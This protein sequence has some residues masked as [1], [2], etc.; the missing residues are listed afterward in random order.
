MTI[1]F[2][3]IFKLENRISA[4][5]PRAPYL[6]IAASALLGLASCSS[7][8]TPTNAA[9]AGCA[10]CPEMALVDGGVFLMGRDG[11]EPKRY[12]GPVRRI[13]IDKPYYLSKYEVTYAQFEAFV[14]AENYRPVQ[15][16]NVFQNGKWGWADWANWQN[17]GLSDAPKPQDPVVCVSWNDAT[18]Y[19]GW[20]AKKTGQPYRLPT[21]AEWEFAA[22]D[23][24]T[25][26]FAWDGPAENGCT[27]ANMFDV[28]G[29]ADFPAAPWD[30]AA[31]DDGHA[32]D[33]P[34]GSFQPTSAGI[35]DLLGNVWEWTQDCYVL[36]YP[37]DGPRDG[38]AVEVAG[39]CERRTV[40]GGSWETRPSRL[41]PAFRGRDAPEA[42]FRTFGIRVARDGDI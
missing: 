20:L 28:T 24:T 10:D 39:E 22:R 34:V 30:S 6:G 9:S 38:S 29:K 21:E 7:S 14:D 8:D 25:G 40:R 17:P 1:I 36:P 5:P 26:A 23:G 42:G 31:C 18:A 33:A 32:Q 27:A 41:A 12:D 35:Y 37:E 11:G 2:A 16:C 19:V 15:G 3:G 4:H 13:N